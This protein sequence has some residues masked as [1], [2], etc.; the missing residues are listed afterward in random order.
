MNLLLIQQ[1]HGLLSTAPKRLDSYMMLRFV[2]I[3]NYLVNCEYI[4]NHIY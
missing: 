1:R 2:T 3:L 4:H